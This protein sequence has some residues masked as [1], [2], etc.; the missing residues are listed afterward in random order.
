MAKYFSENGVKAVAVHSGDNRTEYTMGR[1]EAIEK[2]EKGQIDV[3]F[4]VD[5]FNEGVDIPSLDTVLF[6]RPTE[7]YVVFLQ[8]LGRG[9]R[10]YPNKEYLTVVG[11]HRKLQEGSLYTKASIR[12]KSFNRVQETTGLY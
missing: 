1:D 6:L 8:Q 5:I 10:K 3:I 4:A 9:L 12:R 2:L 7:S 11:F